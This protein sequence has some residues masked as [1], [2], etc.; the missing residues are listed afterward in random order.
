MIADSE[1]HLAHFHPGIAMNNYRICSNCV[2]DTSDSR[3]TFDAKGVCDHCRTF[4]AKVKP[5]GH[6]G[7]RGERE[8]RAMVDEIKAGGRDRDFDCII[9][10]SGGID[11]SY[12]IH[13]ST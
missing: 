11:S 7:E 3:I 2:M 8:R 10:M 13:I 6:T 12:L 9:G 4:F 1:S 5:N